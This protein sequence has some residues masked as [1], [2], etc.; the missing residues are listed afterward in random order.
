LESIPKTEPRI[1]SGDAVE[2][3]KRWPR[4]SLGG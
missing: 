3:I 1:L 4:G 2:C